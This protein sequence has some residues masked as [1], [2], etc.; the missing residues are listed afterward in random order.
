MFQRKNFDDINCPP[1]LPTFNWCSP[2]NVTTRASR[3]AS[4]DISEKL[5]L[6][7]EV[8]PCEGY[9]RA[10][11]ARFDQ[12]EHKLESFI[13]RVIDEVNNGNKPKDLPMNEFFSTFCALK[14]WDENHPSATVYRTSLNLFFKFLGRKY[15]KVRSLKELT[16]VMVSEYV[17]YLKSRRIFSKRRN[18]W[19]GLSERTT[20]EHIKK[21]R[22]ALEIVDGRG[23]QELRERLIT[24]RRPRTKKEIYIPTDEELAKIPEMLKTLRQSVSENARYLAFLAATIL[25][26]CGR[27][28]AIS[29]LRFD[30]IEENG[31][32][33]PMSFMH[34]R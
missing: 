8:N 20:N 7:N 33:E 23:T 31:D 25:Q 12:L 29:R 13:D 11:I 19:E 17:K 24:I 15:P 32:H 34:A 5:R 28:N 4:R 22:H 21:L 6:D 27:T 18:Q 30:M 26:F 1:P 3:F 2:L 14:A 10:V 9:F 16:A